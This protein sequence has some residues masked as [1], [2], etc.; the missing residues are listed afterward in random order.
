MLKQQDSTW[1][2]HIGELSQRTAENTTA[3]LKNT[4]DG[5]K[6][7]QANIVQSK[8]DLL[9][10]NL[11][12]E[13]RLYGRLS[14]SVNPLTSLTV[15]LRVS[16]VPKAIIRELWKGMEMTEDVFNEPWYV[17]LI[18]HHNVA[19]DDDKSLSTALYNQQ[20]VQ[21]FINWL[22]GDGFSRSIYK[23]ICGNHGV[24]E[25]EHI[26]LIPILFIIFES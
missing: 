20:V 16:D 2:A 8:L 15:R 3:N 6:K 17:D 11:L 18:D 24:L 26:S 14:A 21:P 4:I 23:T 9:S 12:R 5:F 1:K 7:E 22:G 10:D 13:T 25:V 19:A